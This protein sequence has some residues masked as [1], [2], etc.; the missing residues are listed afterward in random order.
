M[1]MLDSSFSRGWPNGAPEPTVIRVL[2]PT[3][4]SLVGELAVTPSHEVPQRVARTRSVQEGWA[5]LEVKDR[6]RRLR[7]LLDTVG[8]RAREIEETIVAETGKPR[9]EALVEVVAVLDLL[10]FYLAKAPSFLET[11]R[12]PTGWLLWKS[13]YLTREPLGVIGVISPWN[14]PFILSMSPVIT[15]LFGGNGAVLKPS[16]YTPYTGLFA[17]D[18]TR[19]AGLPQGLVQVIVGPGLTGEALV[20]SGVDKVVFTGGSATGRKVL[21]SAAESLTPV[22]LELGGK[23][24]AIVLEDAP[25]DRAAKGVLWG[26][27]QN[28]GQA[29]IGV[30]RVFVVEEVYDLFLRHLLDEVRK[31][32]AGSTPGVDMGPMVVPGQ[33]RK[34]EEQLQDVLDRGGQVLAGGHRADPASNVFHPTILG[35]VPPASAVLHE[36][37]FGPLIPLVRVKNQEEAIRK[38]NESRYALSASVWSGDR[39]RGME[40]AR[41]LR[42]G[43]VTVN[44]VLVHYGLPGLPFGGVGESGFGRTKGLDGLA[45]LT[46][47]QGTVVDRIGL[48]REPWWF[49]YSRV[50][51]TALWATVLFRWKGGIR[52]LLSGLIAF[53]RR[54][55][56]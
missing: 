28:A 31:I 10:R 3:D 32:R 22:I 21:A 50:T 47:T 23:D 40:V 26:G 38:T 6:V 13:A 46:R 14:Y 41:R 20:R 27:L 55:R 29:C 39:R 36:E 16:E 34:V 9:T 52:G 17:E 30:E 48:E 25:L 18:L 11:K 35:D 45:E 4:G 51:E 42:V 56:G 7:G 2:R 33:L 54:M 1:P 44:D 37:T 5:S 15:A 53:V 43:G 12:I 19:D 49:P 24:A 8:S